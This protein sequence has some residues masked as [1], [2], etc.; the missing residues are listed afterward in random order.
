MAEPPADLHTRRPSL[1][2]GARGPL[3]AALLTRAA[4]ALGLALTVVE[5][6]DSTNAELVRQARTEAGAGDGDDAGHPGLWHP[7]SGRFDTAGLDRMGDPRRPG[8]TG[9]AG[10]AGRPGDRP[11]AVGR[12][13]V[14]ERQTAGRG[15]MNRSWQ[16]PPGSGL[17]VSL[18]LRPAVPMARL[19]W[20]PLVVGTALVGSL[21]AGLSVP[22]EL[23]WP[24]DV[25]VGGNK[26]AGIL[27]EVVPGLSAP[28]SVVVGFGLNVTATADELPPGGTSLLLAGADP[29]RLDR[30]ALLA[31]FLRDIVTAL[32][33]W[34]ADPDQAR[35]AYLA[36]CGTLGREVRVHLPD[37][38]TVRGLATDV[39]QH[40]RLVVNGRAF[41]AA[42]VVHLR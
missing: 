25:L 33:R 13:L 10:A 12:V 19:G 8:E 30:S 31:D 23:K 11:A 40:G 28:P 29:A 34:E 24:N 20:L 15:R 5:E 26:L 3:D 14:A 9:Q 35:D 18:L 2:P 27:A 37:S 41:G 36:V 39:D 22:A 42:D 6:I 1:P 7:H 4:A 17:T 38:S 21:R 32:A 16:S